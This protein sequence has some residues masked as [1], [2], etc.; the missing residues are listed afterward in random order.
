MIF[1]C[2]SIKTCW[3]I[4]WRMTNFPGIEDCL[5]ARFVIV[6]VVQEVGMD[7]A[8]SC[9]LG[10]FKRFRKEGRTLRSSI[11]VFILILLF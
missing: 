8:L 6:D 7:R 9:H 4:F 1:L 11:K 10:T 5:V 2:S 3:I